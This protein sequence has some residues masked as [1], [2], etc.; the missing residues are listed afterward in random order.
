[1][2]RRQKP[3]RHA[4]ARTATGP[5]APRG[6]G[7]APRHQAAPALPRARAPRLRHDAA[8]HPRGHCDHQHAKNR[9]TMSIHAPA[10]GSS[11]PADAP[12]PVSGVPMPNSS[13]TKPPRRARHRQVCAITAS[14]ATSAGATQLTNQCRNAPITGNAAIGAGRLLAAQLRQPRLHCARHL[15]REEPNI[16]RPSA[17]STAAKRAIIQGCWNMTLRLLHGRRRQTR[18]P[19][20]L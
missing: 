8:Q 4:L 13:Q 7:T 11:L 10:L 19:R 3:K 20:R 12:P 1:V 15:Q 18:R 16:E 5:V 17:I 14:T 9:L 2:R 6:P